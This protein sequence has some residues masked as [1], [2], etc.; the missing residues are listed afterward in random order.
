MRKE[1]FKEE[2]LCVIC[3]KAGR[4]TS[5]KVVD[6]IVPHKGDKSLFYDQQ[7]LQPLCKSCHDRKTAKEDG[8]WGK[9]GTVY[10]Y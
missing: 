2:P 7:N 1:I 3:L 6:H 8:R 10:T 9:K 5:A 4:T